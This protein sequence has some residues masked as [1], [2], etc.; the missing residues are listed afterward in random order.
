MIHFIHEPK[1][2][3]HTDR[4][5][6]TQWFD[7]DILIVTDVDINDESNLEQIIAQ[8]P[9]KN[10]L[11]DLSHNAMPF[12][13][14]SQFINQ[15]T[16]LSTFY[17][18]WYQPTRPNLHYFPLWLW[19]F[20][21]RSNQF[22]HPVVFDASGRKT[23]FMMCLNRQLHPHRQ[24]FCQMISAIADQ[25][26]MSFGTKTLPGECVEPNNGLIKIDIGVAHPVYSQCAVN[27]VTETVIDR[28]SLSEKSCKPF[29]ARQIPV[30]V[31]PVGANQFLSDIGLD[32]FADLVPWAQWDQEYNPTVRMQQIADFLVQWHDSGSV[33]D[34]YRKM[35]SRI[36]KNKQY[37]HSE[38]FRQ[39][40]LNKM[41]TANHY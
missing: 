2:I 31:G 29:V 34:D 24:Q 41:P 5:Y 32:M 3:V 22:F 13:E 21:C 25:I 12:D 14:I 30:I 28:P 40:I 38:Q 16:T 33:L 39:V 18:D 36:E 26:Q 17:N 7:Q 11:V 23:Q 15:Y 1:R 37:F 27:I 19:M 4:S 10:V 20:S 6:L 9:C 35:I 8:H